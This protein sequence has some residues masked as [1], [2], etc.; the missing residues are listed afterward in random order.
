MEATEEVG[1]SENNTRG[2]PSYARKNS[3]TWI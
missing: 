2:K 3:S 1:A